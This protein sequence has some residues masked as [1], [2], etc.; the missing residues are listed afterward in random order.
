MSVDPQ[1]NS[2]SVAGPTP[3]IHGTYTPQ[4]GAIIAKRFDNFDQN[5]FQ[6]I[7][8]TPGFS[9]KIITAQKIQV[10]STLV[11]GGATGVA[12]SFAG[13]TNGQIAVKRA[14]GTIVAWMGQQQAV[15][16]DGSQIY[17]GWF[18]QLW[19]GGAD[20][21]Y[22]PLYVNSTGQVI[23]GGVAGGSD[24]PYP[25]ISIRDDHGIEMGRIGAKLGDSIS[26]A[27]AGLT[28]GAWFSQLAVGGTNLTNW[29]VLIVPDATKPNQVNFQIR[30]CYLFTID[31]AANSN[32]QGLSNTH[33]VTEFGT[34][35]WS[36]ASFFNAWSFPGIRIYN[37][38]RSSGGLYFGIA[39][40]NRGIV[41]RGPQSGN[42]M[43]AT[44][45]MFNGTQSG[46]DSP[47]TFWGELQ[48]FSPTGSNKRN[49]FLSSGGPST[50]SSSFSFADA[51]GANMFEMQNNGSLF[52]KG[53]LYLYT[54]TLQLISTGGQW[55]AGIYS[56]GYI[57][58]GQQF[59]VG[60]NPVIDTSGAFV[61]AGV[62]CT[63][64]AVGGKLLGVRFSGNWAY[65]L[66][67][68][69]NAT[70]ATFTTANGKTVTVVGGLIT[71][72]V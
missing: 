9:A 72:I 34:Q 25:Y 6:W 11:V 37:P 2:N 52:M 58:T 17:G 10:G 31:Y 47:S 67:D 60:A 12:A 51:N 18:A 42:P 35:V 8:P 41:L 40:L 43:I 21:R 46:D 33:Y 30:N 13:Q 19:V 23:V 59:N 63:N 64:N 4:T 50:G 44:L 53:P 71:S 5:E 49:V 24:K 36:G 57:I 48:L 54:G 20:P 14:D 29:N 69:V 16:G 66:N 68:G 45:D 62:A 65:G 3:V 55:T 56:P 22:A 38:D 28:S 32:N 1:G 70:S 7:D 27:P 61:G 15:Q 26:G 39:V